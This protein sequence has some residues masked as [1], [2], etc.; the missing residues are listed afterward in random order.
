ME[1]SARL[2][3]IIANTSESSEDSGI[4]VESG[5]G[6]F[7]EKWRVCTPPMYQLPM[8]SDFYFSEDSRGA[9]PESLYATFSDQIKDRLIDTILVP[10]GILE[11]EEAYYGC[12]ELKWQWPRGHPNHRLL[13][14]QII[15][16]W[17]TNKR[18]S[19]PVSH[20][21][22]WE[23]AAMR[24]RYLANSHPEVEI[25]GTPQNGGYPIHVEI[26]SAE[27]TD[28]RYFDVADKYLDEYPTWTPAIDGILCG[29]ELGQ[30]FQ[31]MTMLRVGYRLPR[32]SNPLTILITLFRECYRTKAWDSAEAEI[33]AYLHNQ[34]SAPDVD[35]SIEWGDLFRTGFEILEP[36]GLNKLLYQPDA[37]QQKVNLGSNI[38]VGKYLEAPDGN[39]TSKSQP[40]CGTLGGYIEYRMK[41]VEKWEKAALTC[42]HVIR[43]IF[44]GFQLINRANAPAPESATGPP[45]AGSLLADLDKVG[46]TPKSL[47]DRKRLTIEAPSRT[48]HNHTLPQVTNI[49]STLESYGD[50]AEASDMRALKQKIVS[51]FDNGKQHLGHPGFGSGYGRRRNGRRMD[52]AALQVEGDRHGT[53]ALHTKPEW[54]DL[55][56]RR[57]FPFDRRSPKLPTPTIRQPPRDPI[58]PLPKA[59]YFGKGAVTGFFAGYINGTK[60]DVLLRDDTHLGLGR[61]EELIMVNPQEE[62]Q[63]AARP[64]DSGAWVWNED[65]QLVGMVFGGVNP[66]S[67]EPRDLLTYVTPIH[68]VFEDI[69]DF[70]GGLIVE[71]RVADASP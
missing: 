16:P 29:F 46:F 11:K 23:Y 30:H 28:A 44:P 68:D 63:R 41:G 36:K 22:T 62:H 3:R 50:S 19:G 45:Q 71:I 66:T 13:T 12:I 14:I 31:T 37:Y 9:F 20:L 25:L 64:S 54:I 1:S 40:G 52:W 57:I 65:S 32:E 48:L 34:C 59:L 33:R 4:S 49:L 15:A 26:M 47:T 18:R 17:S 6:I 53:N 7:S 69:K 2:R 35:V 21:T 56:K 51:F 60:S 55:I 67:G 39:T 38:G 43:P 58:G 5:P 10:E 24:C 42:Y 27:L 8:D 61:S 70:S